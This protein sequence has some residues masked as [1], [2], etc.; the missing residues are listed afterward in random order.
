MIG[1]IYDNTVI[2]EIVIGKVSHIFILGAC[3]WKI[4]RLQGSD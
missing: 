4:K 2:F 3:K 1:C